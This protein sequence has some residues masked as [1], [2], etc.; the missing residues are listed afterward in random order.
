MIDGPPIL[1]IYFIGCIIF[2]VGT[3]IYYSL[4]INKNIFIDF[5]AILGCC[6]FWPI[7]LILAV[8]FILAFIIFE[9]A[10]KIWNGLIYVLSNIFSRLK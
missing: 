2:F 9:I 7:A 1:T 5:D 3:A 4:P 10:E 6:I 8:V